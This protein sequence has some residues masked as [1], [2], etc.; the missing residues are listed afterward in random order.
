MCESNKPNSP[1][2]FIDLLSPI[3]TD[4]CGRYGLRASICI[5]QSAIETGW[6]KRA[7]GFNWFG[8]KVGDSE[9]GLGEMK[10]TR[11]Y[12]NG[13]WIDIEDEFK[14]YNTLPEAVEDYC[15]LLT[16]E[17]KYVNALASREDNS[18]EAYVKAFANVYATDPS[19][20]QLILTVIGEWNLT[21][22]DEPDDLEYMS[23][24]QG[25]S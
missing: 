23:A 12:I 21:Q 2:E 18:L 7:I 1:E 8:R 5:A 25:C 20:E 24:E 13:Q 16:Q 22:F 9:V 10:S 17:P 14:R 19:Y 6:G 3:A 11:E 15:I 4:I